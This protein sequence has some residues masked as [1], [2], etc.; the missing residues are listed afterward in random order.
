MIEVGSDETVAFMHPFYRAAAEA[1][2]DV[3]THPADCDQGDDD[4]QTRA[5]LSCARY[6]ARDGA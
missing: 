6:L 4:D 2:L 3:D 5:V 1:L